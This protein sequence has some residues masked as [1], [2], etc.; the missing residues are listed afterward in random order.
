MKKKIHWLII[1][2]SAMLIT[3]G[4]YLINPAFS[5]I[6]LGLFILAIG[7][8]K[9]ADPTAT[10]FILDTDDNLQIKRAGKDDT[11]PSGWIRV[12]YFH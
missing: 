1:I 10:Y 6:V 4:V 7:M 11:L 12:R 3:N 5:Y 8:A 2:V 9:T